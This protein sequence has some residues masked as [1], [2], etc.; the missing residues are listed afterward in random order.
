MH[1]QSLRAT[2]FVFGLL[3]LSNG[4]IL[5][6]EPEASP[7]KTP[8][9][10]PPHVVAPS[11]VTP[12][13]PTASLAKP[14][15]CDKVL[16]LFKAAAHLE[17][18]GLSEDA[19]KIWRQAEQEADALK[20][21]T[22]LL[23]ADADRLHHI[24]GDV[25]DTRTRD[26]RTVLLHL[27]IVEVSQNKLCDLGFLHGGRLVNVCTPSDKKH[28]LSVVET[29][30]NDHFG[31]LLA[32][33]TMIVQNSCPAFF[34]TGGQIPLPPTS[35]SASA[36]PSTSLRFGTQINLCPTILRD[37]KIQINLHAEDSE[38]DITHTAKVN[39]VS[40]PISRTC[41]VEATMTV[42]SGRTA[43]L[44]NGNPTLTTRTIADAKKTGSETSSSPNDKASGPTKSSNKMALVV[45]VTPEIVLGINPGMST[46]R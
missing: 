6:K 13:G 34:S 9:A 43:V 36:Q 32:Q 11:S 42:P 28:F 26:T 44:C 10:E 16:H 37:D 22:K 14:Q 35:K 41:V 27:D 21:E 18:V 38:V 1:V 20:A 2:T 46:A 40:M 33:P 12:P 29:L 8:V 17:A 7:N 19:A 30:A 5:A 4:T 24:V 15:Q 23:R 31:K 25:R 45:L 39:G 3:L